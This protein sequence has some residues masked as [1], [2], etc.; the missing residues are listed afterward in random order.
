MS[1]NYV[2][3]YGFGPVTDAVIDLV[4]AHYDLTAQV[5]VDAL[6]ALDQSKHE[7]LE[8]R[9]GDHWWASHM[10]PAVD[11]MADLLSEFVPTELFED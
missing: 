7:E 5:M 3:P 2:S 10:G 8:Y 1:D 6:A 9:I 4:A 11:A